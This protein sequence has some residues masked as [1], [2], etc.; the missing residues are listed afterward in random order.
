MTLNTLKTLVFFVIITISLSCSQ[1]TGGIELAA[2]KCDEL[3]TPAQISKC[4]EKKQSGKKYYLNEATKH[5]L[6]GNKYESLNAL[7]KAIDVDPDVDRVYF[8]KGLILASLGDTNQAIEQFEKTID[9]NPGFAKAYYHKAIALTELHRYNDAIELC[10]EAVNIDPE[11]AEAHYFLA[12]LQFDAQQKDEAKKSFIAA[13]NIWKNKLKENPGF[14]IQQQKTEKKFK[15]T[16]RYLIAVGYLKP[17]DYHISMKSSTEMKQRDHD[18]LGT[19]GPG[20][21]P[22][23]TL[24]KTKKEKENEKNKS[25]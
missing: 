1:K 4:K 20:E 22:T 14:F 18:K 15:K 10:K 24:W 11:Y 17:K 25:H 13:Y 21:L 23:D 12:I 9:K 3:S 2:L 19:Q 16:K 6:Q 8:D 5:L 7:E